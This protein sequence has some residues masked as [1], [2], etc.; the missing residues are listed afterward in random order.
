MDVR[1]V[2]VML[3]VLMPLLQASGQTVNINLNIGGST[4]GRGTADKSQDADK[5]AELLKQGAELFPDTSQLETQLLDM[6]DTGQNMLIT[7]LLEQNKVMQERDKEM[8][9]QMQ[10][11]Q[12]QIKD[13]TLDHCITKKTCCNKTLT[14]PSGYERF[15]EKHDMC[16]K[17]STDSKNYTNARS[18]CQV[19]G[20]HLVMPKDQATNDFLNKRVKAN[21]GIHFSPS[22][23]IGLTD[24]VTRGTW[25]WEDG[26]KLGWENWVQG[27]PDP[28]N[29]VINCAVLRVN[30]SEWID[31][32][33]SS[34]FYYVC[35]VK[36]TAAP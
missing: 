29:H 11:M 5:V 21:Y 1:A 6:T 31:F 32:D 30:N 27:S 18:D 35:E 2:L 34:T 22:V 23:W 24:E 4:G 33:C 20:G 15:C 7:L 36:A 8:Q 10:K 26:T 25:V 17:F 28:N 13:L 12:E 14:C 19:A 9:Q 3:A 16:Y